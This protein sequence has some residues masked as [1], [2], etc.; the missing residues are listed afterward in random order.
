MMPMMRHTTRTRRERGYTLVEAT[1]AIAV[2]SVLLV[3]IGSVLAMAMQAVPSQ[4]DPLLVRLETTQGLQQLAD[5]LQFATHITE[6]TNHAVA[7]IVPDRTGDGL[8]DRIRYSWDGTPGSDLL[9][10]RN[11]GA[12]IVAVADVR[13]ISLSKTTTDRVETYPGPLTPSAEQQLSAHI[14]NSNAYDQTVTQDSWHGQS[15]TP[16]FP[17]EAV[18]WRVSRVRF[19]ARWID[20]P[21]SDLLVQL[22]PADASGHPIGSAVAQE[23][24]HE[25]SLSASMQ[26]H[27]VAIGSPA[28]FNP[29]DS[30]CL[31][32]AEDDLIGYAAV[33]R[34]DEGSD[35]GY[36]HSGNAGGSWN[37][38]HGSALQHELIGVY[39]TLGPDKTLTRRFAKSVRLVLT[40]GD[41]AEPHEITVRPL[42]RPELLSRYWH[43]DFDADPTAVDANGD[44]QGDWVTANGQ[45][46]D[47]GDLNDGVWCPTSTAPA[48][49]SHPDC[50]FNEPTTVDVRFRATGV[51]TAATVWVN[52]DHGGGKCATIVATL[53]KQPGSQT[54]VV[55]NMTALDNPALLVNVPDLPS[56]TVELRLLID[57]DA[58][59]VNVRVNGS[60]AGT[61]GYVRS[62]A[63]ANQPYVRLLSFNGKVVF[64]ELKVRVGGTG[65]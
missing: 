34:V 50:A 53:M 37:F 46:F 5:E 45:P 63:Y 41:L 1:V 33:V 60:S 44:G 65:G 29:G 18:A 25:S 17:A 12:P 14:G 20:S 23:T 55:S 56:G 51:G 40:T 61:Y 2:M 28:I 13:S 32:L 52:A 21:S 59:T 35:P 42:N 54:L 16:V 6:Q 62:L 57:P 26:W 24:V 15:F 58:N 19:V 30:A 11:G 36:L 64:D 31:V 10:T 27:E 3:A 7:F 49:E 8:P 39:F 4:D 38:D 22:W 43:L 48:L 9:R 47:T